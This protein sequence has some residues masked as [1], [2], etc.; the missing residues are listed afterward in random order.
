MQYAYATKVEIYPSV[1]NYL[2][3]NEWNDQRRERD[4]ENSKKKH[5]EERINFQK[6]KEHYSGDNVY[7][8]IIVCPVHVNRILASIGC[9][10]PKN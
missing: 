7:G 9:A 6:Q 4:R 2:D 10:G 3:G 5:E 1:L 8:Q